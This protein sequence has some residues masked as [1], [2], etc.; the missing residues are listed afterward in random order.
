M[1]NSFVNG[2]GYLTISNID[3]LKGIY[4][5]FANLYEPESF[6]PSVVKVFAL[7]NN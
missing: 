5:I 2:S 6:N 7:Y 1:D 4:R 3:K